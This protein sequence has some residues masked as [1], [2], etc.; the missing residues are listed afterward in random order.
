MTRSEWLK[1]QWSSNINLTVESLDTRRTRLAKYRSLLRDRPLS[2][3]SRPF[4]LITNLIFIFRRIFLTLRWEGNFNRKNYRR[5]HNSW[6]HNMVFFSKWVNSRVNLIGLKRYK[7]KNQA[8]P[9]P[10]IQF[11]DWLLFC[12]SL[13]RNLKLNFR[14]WLLNYRL[15]V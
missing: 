4:W 14:L 9:V 5:R 1:N 15:A 2:S 8:G 3:D 13:P 10:E 11:E 12:L 6:C 7:P